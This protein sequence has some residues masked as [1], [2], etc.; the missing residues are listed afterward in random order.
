MRR[1]DGFGSRGP[2][3]YLILQRLLGVDIVVRPTAVRIRDAAVHDSMMGPRPCRGK[4]LACLGPSRACEQAV[5]RVGSQS[6]L[7]L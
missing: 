3:N 2:I 5:L 7:R 4:T 6:H 1:A